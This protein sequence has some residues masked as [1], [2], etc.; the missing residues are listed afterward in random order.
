[1][2]NL[3]KIF[4]A[5]RRA[6]K[7]IPLSVN[8]HDLYMKGHIT[9]DEFKNV[10]KGERAARLVDDKTKNQSVIL[11]SESKNLN[12]T[13]YCNSVIRNM[14]SKIDDAIS[15]WVP[16]Q[17]D[18]V[19]IRAE[20]DKEVDTEDRHATFFTVRI[21][22]LDVKKETLQQIATK[23]VLEWNRFSNANEA[24]DA[25]V[26]EA[27]TQNLHQQFQAIVLQLIRSIKTDCFDFRG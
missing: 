1:M 8:A 11:T 21:K 26:W 27:I 2:S 25:I 5:D 20:R 7:E 18:H 12:L 6:R 19:V 13:P 3:D 16:N 10:A 23:I 17:I 9:A 24:A 4:E 22:L 14:R 15:T